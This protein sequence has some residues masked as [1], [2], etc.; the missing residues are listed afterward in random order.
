MEELREEILR[1]DEPVELKKHFRRMLE[2]EEK[3]AVATI[4]QGWWLAKI[5]YDGTK[6]KL[7]SRGIKWPDLVKAAA[8]IYLHSIAW[9][10][11]KITWQQL[12]EK[13]LETVI[14]IKKIGGAHGKQD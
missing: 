14:V 5:V 13:L 3:I 6:E 12:L 11:D 9:I 1:I 7:R 2:E 4:R 8:S 10:Q